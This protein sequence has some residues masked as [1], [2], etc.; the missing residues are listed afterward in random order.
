MT[1][2]MKATASDIR[3]KDFRFT[4]TAF[5]VVVVVTLLQL[6]LVAAADSAPETESATAL[7]RAAFHSSA[8][9]TSS[10]ITSTVWVAFFSC[11]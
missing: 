5:R 2:D 11:R 4:A 10:S 3:L 7:C 8:I 9:P 1:D 6:V